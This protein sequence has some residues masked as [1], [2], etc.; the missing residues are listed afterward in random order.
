MLRDAVMGMQQVQAA[1]LHLA[2]ESKVRVRRANVQGV[3]RSAGL[4][5]TGEW[6]SGPAQQEPP[7]AQRAPGHEGGGQESRQDPHREGCSKRREA[8]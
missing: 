3:R 7:G 4:W 5:R 6:K 2:W 8:V 1:F